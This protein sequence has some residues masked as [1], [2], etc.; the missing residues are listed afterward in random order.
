MTQLPSMPGPQ[1][2]SLDEHFARLTLEGLDDRYEDRVLWPNTPIAD[3]QPQIEKM[4]GVSDRKS[5]DTRSRPYLI[6]MALKQLID[7]GRLRAKTLTVLDAPCGDA[8]ILGE[9]KRA[10]HT[11]RCYGLDANT[12]ESYSLL[13]RE[14][15]KLYKVYLQRLF[16]EPLPERVDVAM[17]L[18]T[19]R[20]WHSAQL[21]DSEA[22]LAEQA[23]AWLLANAD[24]LVLTLNSDQMRHFN[25]IGKPPQIIGP[26]EEGSMLVFI[27][28]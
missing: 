27:R 15:V 24:I 16:A 26:G 13:R 12:F 22:D 25:K 1:P 18:N 14:G 2:P 4:Q 6:K 17:M 9:I 20:G 21:R 19:F 23:E 5:R 7:K 28:C 11:A 10:W 3:L 8:L